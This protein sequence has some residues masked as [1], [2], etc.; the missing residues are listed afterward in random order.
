M[1]DKEVVGKTLKERGLCFE[2]KKEFY[3]GAEISREEL[4]KILHE[5]TNI[6]IIGDKAV[7]IALEEKLA[8]KKQV[9]EIK[10][11]KHLQII[12]L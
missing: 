1:A 9:I 5:F 7:A 11:V 12:K 4:K 6:N 10:G 3:Q 2:V 8:E